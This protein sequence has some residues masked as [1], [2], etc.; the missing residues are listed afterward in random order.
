MSSMIKN[1]LLHMLYGELPSPASAE[2][3]QGMTEDPSLVEHFSMLQEGKQ[4]LSELSF[5][6]SQYCI[7]RIMSHAASSALAMD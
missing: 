1:N 3:L 7:N 4:C 5:T 2:L 6:P